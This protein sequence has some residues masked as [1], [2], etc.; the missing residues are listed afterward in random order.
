MGLINIKI[1]AYAFLMLQI[2]SLIATGLVNL[3]EEKKLVRN[4]RWGKSNIRS[5]WP[6]GI[7]YYKIVCTQYSKNFYSAIITI[8]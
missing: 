1:F 7:L 5:H 4:K 3:K 6:N 8:L 2:F